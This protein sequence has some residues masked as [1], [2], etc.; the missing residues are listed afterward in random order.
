MKLF[1]PMPRRHI[2]GTAPPTLNTGAKCGWCSTSHPTC[3]S[4]RRWT[5]VPINYEAGRA[6]ELVW[7]F[8]ADIKL[9][10]LPGLKP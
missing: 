8:G 7:A 2:T 3:F 5:L 6:P 4:L 9:L 10:H 1:L